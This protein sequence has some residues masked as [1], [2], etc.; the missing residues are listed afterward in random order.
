MAIVKYHFGVENWIVIH[1]RTMN[2]HINSI[3][4]R[5]TRVKV[6]TEQQTQ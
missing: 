3:T 5:T 1:K 6:S 4:K 2:N